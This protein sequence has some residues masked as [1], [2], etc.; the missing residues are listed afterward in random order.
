M[1]VLSRPQ[2]RE[3][4]RS[5]GISPVDTVAR[6]LSMMPEGQMQVMLCMTTPDL[7]SGTAFATTAWQMIG[8]CVAAV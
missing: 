8:W 3:K 4:K 6:A 7:A 2:D 5:F 1:G